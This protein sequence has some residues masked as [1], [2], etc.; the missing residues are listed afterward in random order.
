LFNLGEA[1][2]TLSVTW[3]ELGLEGQRRVRDLMAAERRWE[4]RQALFGPR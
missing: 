2:A 3:A 1:P 4:C